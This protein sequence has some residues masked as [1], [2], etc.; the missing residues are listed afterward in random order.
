MVLAVNVALVDAEQAPCGTNAVRAWDFGR[1]IRDELGVT[2]RAY[3]GARRGNCRVGSG[4]KTTDLH[5]RGLVMWS[6]V[7][8]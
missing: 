8:A 2:L 4:M 1:S 7:V 3:A 6:Y 5:D